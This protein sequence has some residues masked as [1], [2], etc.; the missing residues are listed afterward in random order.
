MGKHIIAQRR[1]H[2]SLTYRSPS[3]R[4]VSEIKHLGDGNYKIEDIIQA[5]GRNA[6]V[7]VL[8]M[9]YENICLHSTEHM[10]VRKLRLVMLNQHPLVPQIFFQN[11]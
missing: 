1:G 2:G 10:W 3:F 11:R 5:P 6:P 7:L 8:K 9:K 4:H